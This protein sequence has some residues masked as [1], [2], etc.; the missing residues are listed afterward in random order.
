MQPSTFQRLMNTI[1]EREI[2]SFILVYLD[3]ILI[4]SR[5]IEEHWDHLRIALDRLRRAKLYGRLHKCEFLKDNVD[6]LGFEVSQDGI[7]AS[8]EKVK[9][10]LDWPRPQSVH[11]IRSFLGLASYYRKFIKVFS[12]LAKPLTDL[13][14]EKIPWPWGD[15]EANSFTALKVAMATA[16]VLRLPDFEKQFVVT[17]NASDVAVGAI[18]EQNF[19]SRLQPIAFASQKLN[20]TEIRYSVYEREMLGIVWAL[21]QWKHYFQ[22]PYPIIIQTDHAPLRHLPN[23]TSVNNRVWPWLLILQGYNVEIRH[24]R[25]K[26]NPADSLSRQLISDALVRKE[27]VKDAN[28]E[29]VTRLRVTENATDE[30]IQAALHQLF[31]Q[32]VQS[33]QGRIKNQDNQDPQGHSILAELPQG[34]IQSIHDDSSPQGTNSSILAPTAISK[35]QLDNSLKN[36]L[37]TTL[38]S[39]S[40]YSE[41]VQDLSGGTRQIV[42][43]I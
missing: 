35:I 22:G 34:E 43:I 1:F 9:A 17:T 20:A 31:S 29:Y 33:H 41:I 6:Y 28:A 32:S 15:A 36:S 23:Q 7:H 8:P 26:K 37:H 24:I 25:G 18:L 12:Q 38:Q 3:D 13:T 21:G 39:E 5:S 16:P 42:K 2:N 19:G 27:S 30:Q 4:Y 11:D 14:R 40:P 10:V